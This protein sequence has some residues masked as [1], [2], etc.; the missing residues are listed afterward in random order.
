MY[1]LQVIIEPMGYRSTISF[2]NL[3]EELLAGDSL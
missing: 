3:R 1:L 2:T